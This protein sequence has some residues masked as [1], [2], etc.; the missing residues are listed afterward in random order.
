MTKRDIIKTLLA[1]QTR[2]RLVKGAYMEPPDK[3]FPK[4]ADVDANYDLLAKLMI[5]TSLADG[6]KLSEDGHPSRSCGAIAHS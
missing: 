1:K 2:I 6:S 4:K 5:D 3:A